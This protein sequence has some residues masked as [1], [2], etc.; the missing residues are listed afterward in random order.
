MAP[1]RPSV[2][3][4]PR[5]S[6]PRPG[7]SPVPGEGRKGLEAPTEAHVKNR[8][9]GLW[10][11]ALLSEPTP[12]PGIASHLVCIHMH[13]EYE[14]F[15]YLGVPPCRCLVFSGSIPPLSSLRSLEIECLPSENNHNYNHNYLRKK[16]TPPFP[17]KQAPTSSFRL[18]RNF[19]KILRVSSVFNGSPV[20]LIP[21]GQRFCPSSVECW[22]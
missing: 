20:G 11:W 5:E 16:T 15:F 8:S 22:G 13:K 6:V 7:V 19:L 14:S 21:A 2:L 9:C 12:F 4:G 10:L 18:P 3:A 1:P 17:G